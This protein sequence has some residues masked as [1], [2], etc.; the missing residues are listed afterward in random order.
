MAVTRRN[1]LESED[2]RDRFLEGVVALGQAN[3]QITALDVYEQ[4]RDVVPGFAMFGQNQ[5]LSVWDL[6]VV[7]H[8]AA[9]QITTPPLVP[10]RNLAHGGP[11]FLPW[12][13][14]FLLRL[15]QQLQRV[16]DA[17]TALP[18]WDWAAYGELPP[19]AQIG[20]D[21]WSD[22]WLGES[23]GVVTSGPLGNLRVRLEQRENGLWSIPPRRV[24]RNAA[25][26]PG[27]PRLPR[28]ADVRW[29]LEDGDYDEAGWDIDSSG[30]RNTIEGWLARPSTATSPGQP[31]P[32]L[33][34]RVHVWVGGDMGPG[35]SPNDP[36][37]YLNHCNADR[38]WEAW[39]RDRGRAYRPTEADTDAPLGH[40]REDTMVALL[41]DPLRPADVLDPSATNDYDT[42]TVA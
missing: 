17:D 10:L 35:T 14:L 20:G 24:E 18:Y 28:R 34:N 31:A 40:R 21:L 42:L 16:T 33:H 30:F 36:V 12:H 25:R 11:I 4:L 38:I 19:S 2:A 22:K 27:A 13:R 26:D 15:E 9:M 39:M 6:F 29:A 32:N 37:F 1:V 23:R 7:W 8:Y 3:T 41:G 5:E